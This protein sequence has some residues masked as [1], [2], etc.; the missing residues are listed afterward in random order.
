MELDWNKATSISD[1]TFK[2]SYKMQCQLNTDDKKPTHL[3]KYAKCYQRIFQRLKNAVC[4]KTA[5]KQYAK[6]CAAAASMTMA[7]I[8]KNLAQI[9]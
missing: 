6:K 8:L 5:S 4:A 9:Q 1:L 2:L 3:L 7:L